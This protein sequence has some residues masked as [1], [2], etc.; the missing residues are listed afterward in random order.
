[1]LCIQY[2]FRVTRMK[3]NSALIHVSCS[4][5]PQELAVKGRFKLHVISGS[6]T[7]YG[8][9]ISAP[10]KCYYHVVS[11][12]S[13]SLLTLKCCPLLGS[14]DSSS[15][16]TTDVSKPIN[17]GTPSKKLSMN[18]VFELCKVRIYLKIILGQK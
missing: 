15:W 10:S 17:K 11:P 3:E 5:G 18:V 6:V 4:T 13:S 7:V 9:K 16:N 8:F 1:M 12:E 2:D 14:N